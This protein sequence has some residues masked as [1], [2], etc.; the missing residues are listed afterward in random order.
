MA[1][2]Q[3]LLEPQV[4]TR[5]ISQVA[6]SSD[7][8]A[9]LLGVQPGG[10][11]I[12]NEGHGREGAYHIY[13]NTRKIAKGRAPGTAAGRRPAQGM[14]KVKFDYPRMHDSVAMKAET[15]HNLGK[16]DNPAIRDRAGEEFIRRQTTTLSQLAGNWRKAMCVGMMRDSLYVLVNGDDEYLVF[17]DPTLA[18][19][20]GWRI[21]FQMP[22]G[23]KARLNMTG[24][25]D[26]ITGS[27]ASD[28]TDVP[29]ILGDIN[30]AFQQLNG[31]YL[32]ATICNWK[33]W[34]AITN[35]AFVAKKHGTSSPPFTALEW[36]KEDKMAK[37]MKNVF[38][39]RLNF[40]PDTIFY[41]TD[42]VMEVGELGSESLK[43]IVETNRCAFFGFDPG[44]EVVGCYEGS[45]PIAE[46]DGG[47]VEVKV[48]LQSWSVSRS[49]PT[50]TDIY[51][52][53]NAMI[54]NHIPTSIAYGEVIF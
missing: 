29:L 25:G 44:D 40:M 50:S 30:A 53:D 1:A 36:D 6:A 21:N 37:T 54:V 49:N 8:L 16:I 15:L 28:A 47:P 9:N 33:V 34:N 18:G 45:E 32:A 19:K 11:N 3:D 42:E 10:K 51:V 39:C 41:V 7:W 31:G 52:L 43:K 14:G 26:L 20:E 2:L 48:G 46:Y 27:F 5:V 35:N 12:V 13:N 4:L 22:A 24:S 17:D 38:R 23:N